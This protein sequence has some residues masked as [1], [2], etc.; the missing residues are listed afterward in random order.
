[1]NYLYEA[2]Q[3]MIVVPC[4]ID[5]WTEPDV[6]HIWPQQAD[7]FKAAIAEGALATNKVIVIPVKDTVTGFLCFV[8]VQQRGND[9]GIDADLA[10]EALL[11]GMIPAAINEHVKSVA[12][13]MS[14]LTNWETLKTIDTELRQH[15]IASVFYCV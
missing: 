13:P 14:V 5:G 8:P 12:V 2:S 7:Q 3:E 15:G 1:M 11:D 6:A 9:P 10:T 4:S